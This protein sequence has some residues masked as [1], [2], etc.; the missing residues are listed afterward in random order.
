MTTS[1]IRTKFHQDIKTLQD[2]LVRMGSIVST[3][4]RKAMDALK[5]RDMGLARDVIAGD[6][7]INQIRLELEERCF[8]LIAQQQ[9]VGRDLRMI[10]AAMNI[11]LELERMGDHAAGMAKIA[12]Q[13][14]EQPPLKPLID[15]PK[16]TEVC[17]EILRQ[18]LDAF[19]SKD[20]GLAQATIERDDEVDEYYTAIFRELV[21]FMT[22]DPSTVTR[23]LYLLFV[24]HNLERIGDRCENI[25]ERVGFVT[26]GQIEE[27]SGR[28]IPKI[29]LDAE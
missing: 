22:D 14:G 10:I 21:S 2:D 29:A 4:I 23:G 9:P 25:C 26:T 5:Y 24:A 13:M 1:D 11:V 19:I 17:R 3:A 20:N 16:M 6:A 8:K 18:S 28:G 15:L 27:A 12:V 7:Q